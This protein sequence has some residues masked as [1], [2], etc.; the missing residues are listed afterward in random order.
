MAT[1]PVAGL[2]QRRAAPELTQPPRGTDD[3]GV[4]V[5]AR[6]LSQLACRAAGAAMLALALSSCGGGST[7]TGDGGGGGGIGVPPGSGGALDSATPALIAGGTSHT[8]AVDLAGDVWCWGAN[9][10]GQLGNG[11]VAASA[12]P[13]Q[14]PGVRGVVALTAGGDH[15]CVLQQDGT[16]LCWGAG[17]LGQ[18]GHGRL[19]DSLVPAA[20]QRLPGPA[21][22]VAAGRTHTCALIDDGSVRCWG[23][24]A[25]GQLGRPATGADGIANTFIPLLV[26]GVPVGN[27]ALGAGWDHTCAARAV[28]A[29]RCWGAN[30]QG[31]AGNGTT[32][33]VSTAG[34]VQGVLGSASVLALA[35]G[36]THTCALTDDGDLFC[37]GSNGS[38][39][40]GDGAPTATPVTSAVKV[41]LAANN[42]FVGM[43]LG[44]RFTCA[45]S[46]R[47]LTRQGRASCWGRNANGQLGQDAASVADSSLP[48]DVRTLTPFDFIAVGTGENH[49]C[50]ITDD[51]TL[52]CWGVNAAGQLGNGRPSAQEDVPVGVIRFR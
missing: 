12:R 38:G 14:V 22:A 2:S 15:T 42:L 1:H 18:L 37:W 3:A 32:D 50:A 26:P 35:G 23:S 30:A 5:G 4:G 51:D 10:V 33:A 34:L 19:T 9:N 24:N 29:P 36:A 49:G 11:G 44:D 28:G 17:Q 48:L 16:V 31:Q 46:E 20:V 7:N 47:V 21:I 41:Q 52:R 25:S 40:L 6:S 8:C 43:S 13:V 39:E 45:L 27:V